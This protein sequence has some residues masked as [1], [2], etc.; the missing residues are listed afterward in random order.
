MTDDW[1]GK[2][3]PQQKL[4]WFGRVDCAKASKLSGEETHCPCWPDDDCCYCG[5]PKEDK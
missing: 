3:T 4:A 1:D 2:P 5:K